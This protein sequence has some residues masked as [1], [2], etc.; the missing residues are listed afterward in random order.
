MSKIKI[1]VYGA[2]DYDII[3]AALK[4]EN[5]EIISASKVGMKNK[6]DEDHLKYCFLNDAILLTN[7]KNFSQLNNL[8]N[9]NGILISYEFPDPKKFMTLSKIIKGLKNIEKQIQKSKINLKNKIYPL[10]LFI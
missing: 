2:L 8:M 7:D 6:K 3:R 9:H 4:R 1:Y 10:N 5:F